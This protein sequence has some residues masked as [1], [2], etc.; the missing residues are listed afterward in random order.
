LQRALRTGRCELRAE[1]YVTEVLLDASGRRAI[2]VRYLDPDGTA[3]EVHGEHVVL[4]A[5]ACETPRL[6]L[7]CDV[8]NSSA[9]V[10]RHLMFPFQTLTVGGFPSSLHGYRGRSVTHLHDDHI[11]PGPADLA[12]AKDAGLPYFR[13]GIVEHGGAAGPILE[14]KNYAPGPS[15]NA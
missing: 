9:L 1:C 2:G 3:H 8:A 6:L 10:G 4:A 12:A 5:G 13:G 14:S 7:Q 15:H 11:V